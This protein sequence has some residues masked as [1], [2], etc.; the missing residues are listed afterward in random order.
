MRAMA[1]IPVFFFGIIWVILIISYFKGIV[2]DVEFMGAI[3][4]KY[5][6]DVRPKTGLFVRRNFATFTL[7]AAIALF[8]A[9]G[10]ATPFKFPK[11]N[12]KKDQMVPSTSETVYGKLE[13]DENYT[14]YLNG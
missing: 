2:N 11:R 4:A 1:F 12:K 9:V 13:K 7:I 8:M 3:S 14:M 10:I 6:A 5:D